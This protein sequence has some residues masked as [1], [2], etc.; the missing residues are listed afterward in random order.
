MGGP[1][2]MQGPPMQGPP[3][4]QGM[5]PDRAAM[6]EQMMSQLAPQQ[7]QGMN[8]VD[9]RLAAIQQLL[10]MLNQGKGNLAQQNL[11]QNAQGQQTLN[12]NMPPQMQQG[13]PGGI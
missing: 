12:P 10:D 8:P 4:G 9:P 1:P 2:Q 3:Q 7:Q 13:M 5:S 11:A 6:L